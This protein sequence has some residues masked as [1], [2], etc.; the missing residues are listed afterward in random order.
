VCERRSAEEVLNCVFLL[1]IDILKLKKLNFISYNPQLS[2]SFESFEE[3][4]FLLQVSD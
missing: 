3:N 4:I 1:F 2:P